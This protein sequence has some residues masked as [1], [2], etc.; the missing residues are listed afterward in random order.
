MA[1]ALPLLLAAVLLAAC[2]PKDPLAAVR[3]AQP[4]AEEYLVWKGYALARYEPVEYGEEGETEELQR[5]VLLK[6][7]S[8][9]W[10]ELATSDEGFRTAREVV[11]YIPELDESGVEAFGLH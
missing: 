7:E 5:A 4:G 3:A 2:A 11:T 10:S 1:R 9:R 6:R 8:G